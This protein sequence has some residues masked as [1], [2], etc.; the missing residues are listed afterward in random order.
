[1]FASSKLYVYKCDLSLIDKI[2]SDKMTSEK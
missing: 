1:M 2:V